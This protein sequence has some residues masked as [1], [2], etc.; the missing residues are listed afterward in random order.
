MMSIRT[1]SAAFLLLV[2]SVFIVVFSPHSAYP[3]KV[4]SE[5]LVEI[6]EEVNAAQARELALE[7]AL[8]SAVSK[9]AVTIFPSLDEKILEKLDSENYLDYIMAYSVDYELASEKEIK[10]MIEADVDTLRL[11]NLL[12]DSLKTPSVVKEKPSV[13]ISI[14]ND[15][16]FPSSLSANEIKREIAIVLIQNGYRVRSSH[17]TLNLKTSISVKTQRSRLRGR[18]SL[19]HSLAAI[20]IKVVDIDKKLIFQA[21]N[22]EYMLG[23]QKREI[24]ADAIKKAARGASEKIVKGLDRYWEF[25]GGGSDLTEISFIGIR[26]WRHYEQIDAILSKSLLGGDSIRKRV[27]RTGRISFIVSLNT[28]PEEFT[29]ILTGLKIPEFSISLDSVGK[30]RLQFSV[31]PSS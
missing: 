21:S 27:F 3:L 4:D 17:G 25:K 2:L 8:K 29:R 18:K 6:N 9:A 13:T 15:E 11:R 10:L 28:K 14:I 16:R 22:S 23:Q 20:S 24:T 1:Y 12:G 7:S 26:N 5:A 31:V 30:N 19:Y